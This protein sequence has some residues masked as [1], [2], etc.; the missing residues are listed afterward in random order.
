MNSNPNVAASDVPKIEFEKYTL[1]NGLQVILHVDRKLPM[2]HVNNWYHVG[3][4]NERFGRTGFAHLFEHMMFEGSKDAN[5]KY[6]GFIEKAGANLFEGG[7]NGTTNEDRTNYFES[8]PSAS[9]EY[10]LWLE[11]DR[12]ATLTDVLTK[13]KLD[14]ERDIVKNERRQGLEN[15]PYGRAA[16]LITENVFPTGHPYAHTVIGSHEDLT[17][18]SVDDVKDFFHTYYTPNN[19]SLAITGDFDVAEAKQLIAKYYGPIPPGP[20]LDRPKHWVPKLTAEKIIE[21]KDHVPQER[22]YFAWPSPAFF[23]PDDANLDL[24]SL[25]L[26]DGLS[27]RLQKSLI[28]D[29]QIC[30]DVVSFQ[31]SSEIAGDFIIWVTARPGASL[32]QAEQVTSEEISRLANEGPTAEELSRAKTK[33]EFQYVTG[34]ER[35]GGF[36]G[37]ADL[38]N[39]YNVFLGDPDKFAADVERHRAVT[40]ENLRRAVAK[41][42][43]TTNRIVIRFHPE[44]FQADTQAELDRAKQPALGADRPFQ[45][46]DVTSAKLENGM[47]IYVVERKDLPKVAVR[48]ASRAGSMADPQGKEGLSSLAADVMRR[49]TTSKR[50]LEID[51]ALGDL[52]TSLNGRADSETA[53]LDFE[54]L[55][56]N[57]A[58]ALAVMADVA[59]NPN[60][61]ADELERERKIRLA[62]LAQ[63]ESQPNRISERLSL[64]LVYGRDHPYGRPTAGYPST[65]EKITRED[66]VYFHETY[67]K[68]GGSALILVGDISLAEATE[69]AKHSFT[70][71]KGAAPPPINVPAPQP[72]GQGKV[73]LVNRPDAAQTVVAEILPGPVRNSQDYYSLSLANA[74][75]GGA[76]GARLGMNIRENKGYSYGV[77]SF[78]APLQRYGMWRASGGVQTNKTKES[79]VEFDKELKF[80]AGDKPITDK[81]LADAK[82]TRVRGYAQ[83]F[84][85][86][87]RVA[88]QIEEMWTFGLPM[89]ELQHEPDEL[90][91][92]TLASVNA[93]AQKYAK[94][95]GAT[96]LLVG[97]LSKIETGVRELNLGEIV[98]LDVEGNPVAKK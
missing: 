60:F 59:I 69:L 11:S 38:L 65:V 28:Y 43:D 84:E 3:S 45:A 5:S 73:F 71:W 7:V 80:I 90:E 94:P 42:L 76:A 32:S 72:A 49:G 40:A 57:L 13:E 44:S 1:P 58:Q 53:T 2:V 10:V 9:L 6:F 27:S 95:S 41:W 16:M 8:V 98:L 34:L 37:K 12:L 48:L 61:P 74:V 63:G 87:D 24:V 62:E 47:R 97:D 92:A 77:F 54:V 86:M 46:P 20:A 39:T 25:M 26:T 85:S 93:A 33:W 91:K 23:D 50:A 78:P 55:K 19:L 4:K 82:H 66:L 31:N 29:K 22:T 35:I 68:P 79:V 15:Q 67:W 83:Q 51:D 18:A 36:G 56:R 88:R 17:A 14:N 96:L 30:S 75:W 52:G 21:V 89:T 64:M 70:A 81:E